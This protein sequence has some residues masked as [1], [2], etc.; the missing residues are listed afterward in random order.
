MQDSVE[1]LLE[2]TVSRMSCLGNDIWSKMHYF[3]R[4]QLT[5]KFY[6]LEWNILVNAT[7]VKYDGFTVGLAHEDIKH[8][9]KDEEVMRCYREIGMGIKID[10]D[11][12]GNIFATKLSDSAVI[13]KGWQQPQQCCLSDEIIQCSGRLSREKTKI[14]DVVKFSSQVVAEFRKTPINAL[15]VMMLGTINISFG[16]DD[17]QNARTPCWINIINLCA[18]EQLG[19]AQVLADLVRM[20]GAQL[21]SQDQS[22]VEEMSQKLRRRRS[23]VSCGG[24]GGPPPDNV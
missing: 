20:S 21:S 2:E 22:L 18:L 10:R 14:F 12:Q 7:S 9:E 11:S 3:E 23:A 24:A 16:T 13:V 15:R 5:G 4:G 17:E 19:D 1:K 6:L 8:N